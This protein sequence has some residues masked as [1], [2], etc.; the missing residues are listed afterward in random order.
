MRSASTVSPAL[1]ADS[2]LGAL[3]D[4]AFSRALDGHDP[5]CAARIDRLPDAARMVAR[6]LVRRSSALRWPPYGPLHR[7]DPDGFDR[8]SALSGRLDALACAPSD[9]AAR[10]ADLTVLAVL[11]DADPG[12]GWKV[13][14]R[15]GA[16]LHGDRGALLVAFNLFVQGALSSAPEDPLRVDASCLLSLDDHAL[17]RAFAAE[18]PATPEGLPRFAARLR[19]VGEALRADPAPSSRL[20]EPVL[21]ALSAL[22]WTDRSADA[23]TEACAALL[24]SAYPCAP[25]EDADVPEITRLQ[26]RA[27][28]LASSL[29]P[30]LASR[31]DP[32]A[33]ALLSPRACPP[34]PWSVSLLLDAGILAWV[35]PTPSAPL[36]PDDPRLGALRAVASG[37]LR[38]LAAEIRAL[39]R[40]DEARLSTGSILAWG[41][42]PAGR[43]LAA[44]RRPSGPA[45]GTPA[46]VTPPGA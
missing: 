45:G 35:V 17:A 43:A 27:M 7:L 19:A 41:V 44:L 21:R 28:T 16:Q 26:E 25:R 13:R 3:A 6:A 14:T 30:W 2:S 11:L 37:A 42:A 4:R 12:A 32:G 9:R 29:A 1:D 38:R 18:G 5:V 22:P 24:R 10:L 31:E 40:L 8:L 34:D 46:I 36:D 39:L 15:T 23:L 20:A 33:L